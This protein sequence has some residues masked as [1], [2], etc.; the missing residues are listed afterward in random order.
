MSVLLPESIVSHLPESMSTLELRH[1]M[2]V[3][4]C[5]MTVVLVL[6]SFGRFFSCVRDNKVRL[7]GISKLLS[8][9]LLSLVPF[10]LPYHLVVNDMRYI[11]VAIGLVFS[12]ITK[13]MIVFS[14]AK[15]AFATLQLDVVP[16][17]LLCVWLHLDDH[18]TD[19]GAS[20]LLSALTLWHTYRLLFWAR[21]AITQ[22]CA[23]LDI[24]CFTIKKKVE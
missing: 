17:V 3:G 23:R 13:K 20:A 4:W 12:L 19:L 15:A 18:F 11:S 10:Y 1:A 24:N 5:I 2:L 14:M 6:L 9:L 21:T 22:I 16:L 8:P 7:S